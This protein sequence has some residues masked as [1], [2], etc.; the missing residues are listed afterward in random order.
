MYWED[1]TNK[2]TSGTVIS[3][4]TKI[5][6]DT[7]YEKLVATKR[8]TVKSYVGEFTWDKPW[9]LGVEVN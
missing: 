3:D 7:V 1:S 6:V 5:N 4:A 2:V 9:E 8:S